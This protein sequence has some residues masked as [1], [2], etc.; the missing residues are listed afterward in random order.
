MQMEIPTYD[1][2]MEEF[3][4]RENQNIKIIEEERQQKDLEKQKRV[5]NRRKAMRSGSFNFI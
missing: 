5:E 1:Q 3:A 4:D 2:I